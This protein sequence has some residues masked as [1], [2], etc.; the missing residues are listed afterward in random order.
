M[1][2]LIDYLHQ[3]IKIG[4]EDG[5]AALF[6]I[7]FYRLRFIVG[8]KIFFNK[9]IGHENNYVYKKCRLVIFSGVPFDDIGGGQ[10]SSQLTRCALKLGWSVL[11]IYI[12]PRFDI[13]KRIPLQSKVRVEGLY[14]KHI[15]EIDISDYFHYV[16]QSSTVVFELP[17]PALVNFLI[18]SKTRG[19]FTV[20]ELIDNWETS[21]GEEWF[22]QEVF[23]SFV[24]ECDTVI[25]TAKNLVDKLTGMGRTDAI[26]LPNA[27][28]EYIFDYYKTYK[29]P[30]DLP[31]GKIIIYF[32][33]MYGE[34]FDW[35]ILQETILKNPDAHICLIGSAPLNRKKQ[36]ASLSSNVHFLGVKPIHHLP[37]YL[38][39]SDV[40]I[41][42]FRPGQITD[43]VSPIKV[44]EYLF[45]HKP[46]ITSKLKEIE[47]YPNVVTTNNPDEFASICAI[48]TNKDFMRSD[49][50][51][52][53]IFKNSWFSRLQTITRTRGKQEVSVIILIHNNRDVIKRCL[54]S[55]YFNCST[56]IREVVVVDNL[57][58][59]DG[60]E[61]VKQHF[62]GVSV[63]KNSVNGCASGRNLGVQNSTGEILA[64]FDS[65]QW[66]TSGFC[67]EE[68]LTILREHGEVGAVSWAAGW[69]DIKKELLMGPIVDYFPNRGITEDVR[70]RKGF[71]TDIDYLGSGGLFVPRS[72]FNAIGGFDTHY[73]PTTFEDTDISF[74]I[75]KLGF[76]LAYRDLT[77]IRHQAHTTTKASSRSPEYLEIFQRNSIYFRNKWKLEI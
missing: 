24:N 6:K 39:F 42:P 38:K 14:H 29:K 12:Y 13:E 34:W 53:F 44:F 64:F 68:A 70:R 2:K 56:Y 48:S 21:L 58:S 27:A 19:I 75:K 11:Y 30:K 10:R 77:G 17:H 37:A 69:L 61:F 57:S 35:E 43:A 46:V 36:I 59:D 62:P 5:L 52:E 18:A 41:L 15:D 23:N 63:V 45:M 16:D 47:N 51:D 76:K 49:I 25:G 1:E 4:K 40:C 8:K 9:I 20:F 65:D 66:F 67:F 33:S 54:A 28:N 31:Q 22:N 55:L 7:I 26:Y 50:I 71:R 3:A 60:G 73:D 32:G 74:A 72:V